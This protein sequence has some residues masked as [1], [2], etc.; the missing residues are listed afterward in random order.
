[1]KK[2][3]VLIGIMLITVGVYSQTQP[4]IFNEKPEYTAHVGIKPYQFIIDG[5]TYDLAYDYLGDKKIPKKL[6]DTLIRPV[7]IFREINDT[8]WVK[9][10]DT[11]IQEDYF[12]GTINGGKY[13]Y[14]ISNTEDVY[15][16]KTDKNGCRITIYDSGKILI[17]IVNSYSDGKEKGRRGIEINEIFLVPIGNKMYKKQ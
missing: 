6:G 5:E 9:A 7:Y 16:W 11:P 10:I 2:L 1:M 15:N 17:S 12:I 14:Y 13:N 3:I 4:W 8:T